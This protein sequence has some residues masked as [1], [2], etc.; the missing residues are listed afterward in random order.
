IGTGILYLFVLNGAD[1]WP[2]FM[3]LSFWIFV[4]ICV[5][6]IIVS[7]LDKTEQKV[8]M[9]KK[10]EDKPSLDV[11]IGWALLIIVMISLYIFFNG[12]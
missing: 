10:I 2:H 8:T 11:K 5:A 1:F 4:I 6:M 9:I 12:H 3:M 7:L